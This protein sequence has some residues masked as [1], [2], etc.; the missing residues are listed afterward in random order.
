M[1]AANSILLFISDND[2]SKIPVVVKMKKWFLM[3]CYYDLLKKKLND[4]Y[5]ANASLKYIKSKTTN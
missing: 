3:G 2:P 4:Q 1:S 5:S